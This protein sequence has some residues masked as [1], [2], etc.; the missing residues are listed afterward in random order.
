[1]AI[2]NQGG[3][4]LED[5]FVIDDLVALSED[6]E[7]A[8][9]DGAFF[10]DDGGDNNLENDASADEDVD[11]QPSVNAGDAVISKKRKRREKEKERKKRKL[12]QA[13]DVVQPSVT[14]KSPEEL[15]EYLALKQAAAY[16]KVTAIELE[17][18]RIPG[19]P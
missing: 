1:M 11:T 7:A 6:D 14:A 16:P 3:D 19:V 5:D 12:A 13:T 4:D 10:S 17:D 8:P 18:M 9:L 15:A 2:M